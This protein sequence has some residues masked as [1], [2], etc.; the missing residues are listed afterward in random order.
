MK[1]HTDGRNS[2]HYRGGL[3]YSGLRDTSRN[4]RSKQTEAEEYIWKFLRAGKQ[5][6]LKFRRQHQIGPYIVDFYCHKL[7]LIIELDGEYHATKEQKSKDR[8]RDDILKAEGFK[9]LR[10]PNKV[11]LYNPETILQQINMLT[12][13]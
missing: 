4:L 7:Q 11:A 8:V 13:L 10:Y 9:I 2:L 5:K 12:E 3:K 6:S 1:D